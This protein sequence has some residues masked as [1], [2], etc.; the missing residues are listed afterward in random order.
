MAHS[1]SHTS[2][3]TLA[4]MAL[5]LIVSGCATYGKIDNQSV[6]NVQHG[7]TAYSV[8]AFNQRL[9]GRDTLILLS[10]SGGGTRAAALSYGVLAELRDTLV[11]QEQSGQQRSLLDD[12]GLISSVSGGSFTAAYYGL[13]GDE[14]FDHFETRFLKKNVEKA[15]IKNV[16]NPKHWFS[17]KSRTEYAIEYYDKEVF[18]GATYQDMLRPDR[19]MVLINATDL[20]KGVRFSFMQEYFNLLCSDL[21]NFSVSRAVTA[22]S[23]VP[24]LFNPVVVKNHEG[25]ANEQPEWL[26]SADE[27]AKNDTE[28]AL[29]VKGLKSFFDK[30]SHQYAHFVDGGI[31]DNLGLRSIFDISK[32]LG[33]AKAMNEAFN[34]TAPS[35]L[36]VISVDASASPEYNIGR[37]E[38]PPRMVDTINAM[39]DI[40][41]HRY[42][43]ATLSEMQKATQQW[44]EELSDETTKVDAHF[45]RVGFDDV[46]DEEEGKQLNSIPTTFSLSSE[47]VDLLVK[48][49]RQLLRNNPVFKEALL[50]I[51]K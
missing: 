2:R 4:S 32:L 36:I 51:R 50:E 43:T 27:R 28:L 18:D 25:C 40:Q 48:T 14:I 33:G 16:L 44:V 22:S 38:R 12:V 13:H 3:R 35:R 41:L 31:T 5:A 11:E 20:S 23:A 45:V 34:I 42:N 39:T 7:H 46:E 37:S 24:L 15:L 47:Q 49:G 6:D 21:A 10:F 8:E 17:K 26:L 19:P 30:D 9:S 29:S 1:I